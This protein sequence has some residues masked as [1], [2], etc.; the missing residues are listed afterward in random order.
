MAAAHVPEDIRNQGVWREAIKTANDLDVLAAIDLDGVIKPRVEHW[1]GK[2]PAYVNY[3]KTWGE[4]GT[5][6]LKNKTTTK[7][8]DQGITCM[9]VG[10]A[11]Q[12]S[13]DCYRMLNIKTM[14]VHETR[15][16]IWLHRMFFK[17]IAPN[18]EHN[19]I[20][21]ID[22]PPAQQVG[23]RE[24][25]ENALADPVNAE[26]VDAPVVTT[27][28]G[29]I[30]KPVNRLEVDP[31]KKSYRE[32][33]ET[34]DNEEN[35]TKDGSEVRDLTNAEVAFYAAIGACDKYKNVEYACVGLG[36]VDGFLDTSELHVMKY[37][38]A[39]KT[40]EASEWQEAVD[41][42]YKRMEKNK[43]F[44]AVPIEEV[45]E[46]SK[47]L[48]S[49]WSMK[50][51]PNGTKRARLVARGYEQID[52][53]HF[54]SDETAAPV[55][56][57]MT[58][59]IVLILVIMARFCGELLDV[60]G[61]FLLGEFG[62]DEKLFM[63]V[64]E[65]F[66]R[67]FAFNVVLMLLKT[68]YGLKQA[69]YAFWRKLIEAFWVMG[70]ERS[71]GDPCLY[72]KWTND[73]ITLWVS[74]VD[75]CFVCGEDS[76]VAQAKRDMKNEFDCDDLGD[77][78]EYVGCKVEYNK[79]EGWIKLTQPVLIQ[80]LSDEFEIKTSDVPKTPAPEGQVL[81]KALSDCLE[82]EMMTNYRKGVGK[83]LH[84]MKWSRP[85]ILNSV[86]EL[87]KYMSGGANVGH[88]RAMHTIMKYV[89][90]TPNRGLLL[91]P[92]KRWDGSK[93]FEFEI[94]GR[95]DSDHGKCP[96]TRKS[97]SGYSVFLNGAPYRTRS[98]MQNIVTLSVTE[99]EEVAATECV[100]DMLFGMHL[101]E[102]LGLKVKKPMVLELDNKG[103]Q[104]IINSWSTSGRTRHI[105]IRHN[106][107]RELKEEG[108]L[109][110]KWI[111]TDENSSDLFTKN[112]GG[113]KFNKFTKTYIG[114][115]EY[116]TPQGESV[117]G[118]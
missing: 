5:V 6:K 56:N 78:K 25:A 81:R 18:L 35:K 100:Q 54:K 107:L 115:D 80:S 106:F 31:Q 2:L 93:S 40:E 82:G 112:L 19:I 87:S 66:E 4:A 111:P 62:N 52:G 73:V 44:K 23:E 88:I 8:R 14:G 39:M 42:E 17:P 43:V 76:N 69:A 89:L 90:A 114:E 74:W 109:V 116:M 20:P 13:G 41:E 102:S 67:F 94:L 79:D 34:H 24:V 55:V 58:I 26:S 7:I 10:Y 50:K 84:L 46:D 11:K 21:A 49:T 92:N 37:K 113:T 53:Q 117:R 63:E 72:F 101:L 28:T 83:L 22:L 99:A 95:S 47:I 27:R 77:L 29:R 32:T 118:T 105:M 104:D 3:L 57:D 103:G 33:R 64:P 15:D 110:V 98:V 45:P 59:R 91:R 108:T 71:K 97:V 75:D 60:R 65:G 70:Y 86:R 36:K 85:E 51:K 12:H 30:I 38:D 61:A 48:T 16:I 9:F 96:D 68:I 1:S